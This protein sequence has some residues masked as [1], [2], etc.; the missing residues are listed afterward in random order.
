MVSIKN[1]ERATMQFIYS[2]STPSMDIQ[3][4]FD[5]IKQGKIFQSN[6]EV[7]R[8]VLQERLEGSNSHRHFSK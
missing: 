1:L 3:I 5:F 4:E 6:F 7:Q 8:W 2:L